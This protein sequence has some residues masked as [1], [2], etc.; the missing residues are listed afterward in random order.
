MKKKL[1]LLCMTVLLGTTMGNVNAVGYTTLHNE[2]LDGIVNS[3]NL[4]VSTFTN[5]FGPDGKVKKDW[6]HDLYIGLKDELKKMVKI[7]YRKEPGIHHSEVYHEQTVDHIKLYEKSTEAG[8]YDLSKTEIQS[9][10][11][12]STTRDR[13]GSIIADTSVRPGAIT[14]DVTNRPTVR[15]GEGEFSVINY[16]TD[17]NGNYRRDVVKLSKDGL[18]NGGNKIINVLPG[19]ADTDAVNVSQLKDSVAKATTTVSAGD[20]ITVSNNQ[21]ANGSTNYNVSVNKNLTDMNSAVFNDNSTEYSEFKHLSYV[22]TYNHIDKRGSTKIDGSV[23]QLHSTAPSNEPDQVTSLTGNALRFTR[24][25]DYESTFNLDGMYVFQ[26]GK[27]IIAN[28]GNI[29]LFGYPDDNESKPYREMQLSVGNVNMG[30]QQVHGVEAGTADTDAVNVGQ[31][32]EVSNQVNINTADI[33]DLKGKVGGSNVLNESKSYTDNKFNA[34][35][36]YTDQ[37]IAKAGAANAALSGLKYLDYDANRKLSAAASFGQYKGA[38]AGAIGLA[39]QPNE[40][41]LIHLGTTIGSDH[42]VNGGVSI[43]VGDTTKGVKANTKNL[44]KEMDAIKAENAELKAELA[45]IKAM[46]ANR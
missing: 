5:S 25:G 42:M 14:V 24:A 39:Y 2:H 45:E 3:D 29:E 1:A 11:M 38:T 6:T 31:L 8:E 23:I 44:A 22:P 46:L 4:A 9:Y 21:N 16:G 15:M 18:D 37:R 43:R 35:N 27:G 32:K 13:D 40:D 12:D 28:G 33:A 7:E 34:A 19:E 10:G 20:N 36:A 30:G 41:V 17:S 26:T